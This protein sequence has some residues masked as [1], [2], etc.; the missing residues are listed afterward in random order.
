MIEEPVSF[1]STNV[2]EQL[3]KDSNYVPSR[4]SFAKFL[5]PNVLYI[6]YVYI[7]GI[8]SGYLEKHQAFLNWSCSQPLHPCTGGGG[9][10]TGVVAEFEKCSKNGNCTFDIG[11]GGWFEISSRYG[12][13]HFLPPFAYDNH[14]VYTHMNSTQE[15]FKLDLFFIEAFDHRIWI[16]ILGLCIAFT[17]LKLCDLHFEYPPEVTGS[18]TCNRAMRILRALQSTV[19]KMLVLADENLIRYK[20]TTRQWIINTVLG[21]CFLVLVLLYEASMTKDVAFGD[22]WDTSISSNHEKISACVKNSTVLKPRRASSYEELFESMLNGSCKYAVMLESVAEA[23]IRKRYCRRILAQGDPIFTSGLSMIVPNVAR[24]KDVDVNQI[25]AEGTL[26]LLMDKR[27][28]HS[29]EYFD[30]LPS[31]EIST[32]SSRFSTGYSAATGVA[33]VLQE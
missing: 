25:M 20:H 2:S 5:T 6:Q 26:E 12:K 4:S 14:R 23:A 28:S 27:K 10:F 1:V 19:T 22:L 7:D 3:C 17:V 15:A 11:I 30:S 18:Q 24:F 13:A 21:F 33:K 29:E 16:C 8:I 9:D 32:P 31:C